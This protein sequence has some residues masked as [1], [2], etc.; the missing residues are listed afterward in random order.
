MGIFIQVGDPP[1]VWEPHVC[2]KKYMVYFA[3]QDLRNIFGFQK[4]VTFWVVLWLVKVGMDDPPNP[5]P[6]GKFPTLS[7]FL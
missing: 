2:E 5:S 4:N 1:P 6:A 3:F 7:R